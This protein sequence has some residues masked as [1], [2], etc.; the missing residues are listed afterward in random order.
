M[1]YMAL[2][3]LTAKYPMGDIYTQRLLGSLLTLLM[4]TLSKDGTPTVH[5]HDV[6]PWLK[7]PEK[8]KT[9]REVAAENARRSMAY[10]TRNR[11]NRT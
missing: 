3:H 11:T 5:L 4:N 6:A 2:E 7:P 8:P 10:S 9:D 1:T